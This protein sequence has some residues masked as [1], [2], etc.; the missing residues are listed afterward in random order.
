MQAEKWYLVTVKPLSDA[1]HAA[2]AS[3]RPRL[4]PAVV[5]SIVG[6]GE[7]LLRCMEVDVDGVPGLTLCVLA[8]GPNDQREQRLYQSTVATEQEIVPTVVQAAGGQM[9]EVAKFGDGTSARY[10]AYSFT[11]YDAAATSALAAEYGS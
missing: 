4:Q 10:C 2:V 6:G 11:R 9:V 1:A 7:V 8:D 5:D 3:P